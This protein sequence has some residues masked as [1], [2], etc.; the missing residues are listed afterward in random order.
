MAN[1]QILGIGDLKAN[2]AKVRI[3]MEARVGRAMV[4][5]AG[6]VLRRIA[7]ANMQRQ[8]LVRTGSMM[9]N[10]AIKR[11]TKAPAGTVQYNLGVRHGRDKS[12]AQRKTARL[13]VNKAGRIVKRYGD[14]PWYWKFPEFGTVKQRATPSLGPALDQ[15]KTEAIAAMGERLKKELEKA[16]P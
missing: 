10:V 8:G 9:K 6:G 14:D 5:S 12:R 7:K 2:F 11:E 1:T 16:K 3:G 13:A 4:V 15:G